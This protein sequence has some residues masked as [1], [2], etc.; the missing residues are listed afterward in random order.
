MVVGGGGVGKYGYSLE[1]QNKSYLLI[2]YLQLCQKNMRRHTSQLTEYPLIRIR[3]KNLLSK[4]TTFTP[5]CYSVEPIE[6]SHPKSNDLT[7]GITSE[8][9]SR[10]AY[11]L[12]E[13]LLNAISKLHI[14]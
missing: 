10:H 1:L 12:A 4:M 6:S 3:K 2:P 9:R 8:K 7:Q 5:L 14:G 13:S 11:F